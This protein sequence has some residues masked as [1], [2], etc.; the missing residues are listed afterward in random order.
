MNVLAEWHM[1]RNNILTYF[2]QRNI[3]SIFVAPVFHA[4]VCQLW[5]GTL[6]CV[7][8]GRHGHHPYFYG[9]SDTGDVCKCRQAFWILHSHHL[10]SALCVCYAPLT[11]QLC[12]HG[13]TGPPHEQLS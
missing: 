8:C 1:W 7:P 4:Q 6:P 11:N 5:P 10:L 3:A 2:L 13:H 12:L 9:C